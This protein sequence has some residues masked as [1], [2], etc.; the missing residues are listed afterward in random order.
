[1]SDTKYDVVGL[2]NAIVD[3]LAHC[4]D[5]FLE[6]HGMAKGGM[7]LI[8][9]ERADMLDGLLT[10][11]VECSGGSVANSMAGLASFGGRAAYIGKVRDDRLGQS[12][13][14]H[15]RQAGVTFE[16]AAATEGA[17]TARCVVLVSAAALGLSLSSESR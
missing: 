1:M 16:T 14:D 2:G 17:S 15:I 7:T 10:D 8:D 3:V 11:T 9:A 4:D 5:A 13:R 6:Q 12:F